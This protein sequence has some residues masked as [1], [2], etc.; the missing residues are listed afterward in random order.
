VHRLLALQQR[1]EVTQPEEIG[2]RLREIAQ[3][4]ESVA[5]DE[6]DHALSDAVTLYQSI[7]GQDEVVQLL[8]QTC[9]HEVPF[10]F[11]LPGETPRVM[12]G[13]VD[14]LVRE[15]ETCVAVV[16]FKT[17]K[18]R[19]EDRVQ[20]EAYLQAARMFFPDLQVRGRLIYAGK[21]ASEK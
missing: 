1:P 13:M 2:R 12:R 18:P 5:L 7:A 16:E 15:D 6:N 8:Q 11:F 17:G 19:D 9:I 20:L 3:T 4:T 10:S 21:S 14:C